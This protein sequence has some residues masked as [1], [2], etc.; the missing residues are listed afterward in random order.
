MLHLKER[1]NVFYL[2]NAFSMLTLVVQH[3]RS[4]RFKKSLVDASGARLIPECAQCTWSTRWRTFPQKRRCY[5]LVGYCGIGNV[6]PKIVK[7]SEHSQRLTRQK[8]RMDNL[9][10]RRSALATFRKKRSFFA[11]ALLLDERLSMR[12]FWRVR[13]WWIFGSLT[14][15]RKDTCLSRNVPNTASPPLRGTCSPSGAPRALCELGY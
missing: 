12:I 2:L 14:N 15:L 6:L 8:M 11:R 3:G 4:W 10:S 13:R 1:W 7:L 9:S 5:V